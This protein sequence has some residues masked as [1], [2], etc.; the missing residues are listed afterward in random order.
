MLEN[1]NNEYISNKMFGEKNTNT[2][3]PPKKEIQ[4][5]FKKF[6]KKKTIKK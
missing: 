2:I 6:I 1:I 4:S 3:F 5:D